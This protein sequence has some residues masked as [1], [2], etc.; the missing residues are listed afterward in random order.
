MELAQTMVTLAKKTDKTPAW[1]HLFVK[2]STC[3]PFGCH[4]WYFS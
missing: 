2:E 3:E 4:V 1:K